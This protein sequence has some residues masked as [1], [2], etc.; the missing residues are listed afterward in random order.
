MAIG[1]NLKVL[2]EGGPRGLRRHPATKLGKFGIG[3]CSSPGETVVQ[4]LPKLLIKESNTPPT[5]NAEADSAGD[6]GALCLHHDTADDTYEWFMQTVWSAVGTH[7][8]VS[9]SDTSAVK[10]PVG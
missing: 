9:V 10:E 7:T 5:T 2:F 6:V 8:W 4:G 3:K 1:S